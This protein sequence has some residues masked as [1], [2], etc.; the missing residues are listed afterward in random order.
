M[1]II[2]IGSVLFSK[3]ILDKLIEIK[4]EIMKTYSSEIENS[5][6]LR[7][8]NNIRTLATLRGSTVGVKATETF[9][10]LKIIEK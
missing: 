9:Q 10:I 4:A 6:F 7:S 3:R 2:Y 5:P 1:K 8:E